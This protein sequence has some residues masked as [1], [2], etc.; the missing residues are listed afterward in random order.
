MEP[1]SRW[2]DRLAA[3]NEMPAKEVKAL[4]EQYGFPADTAFD[5]PAFAATAFVLGVEFGHRREKLVKGELNQPVQSIRLEGTIVFADGHE[6]E[7]NHVFPSQAGSSPYFEYQMYR[8]PIPQYDPG[9][10]EPSRFVPSGTHVVL[11][12]GEEYRWSG[13]LP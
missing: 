4:A 11:H 6:Y 8:P 2:K 1:T 5:F 13:A 7:I 3:L 9:H 10:V 12:I